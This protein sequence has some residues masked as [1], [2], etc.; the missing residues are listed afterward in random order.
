MILEIVNAVQD[1]QMVV[2]FLAHTAIFIGT[3]FIAV[4]SKHLPVWHVTPLWYAGLTSCF[5]AITVVCEWAFG[6]EFPLSY[7]MLGIFGETALNI[8]IAAIALIMML[9]VGKEMMRK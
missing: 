6:P 8:A 4:Y 2:N 1:V 7:S 5:T 9:K 3:L